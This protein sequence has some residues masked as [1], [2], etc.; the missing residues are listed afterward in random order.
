MEKV[1]LDLVTDCELGTTDKQKALYFLAQDYKRNFNTFCKDG[2]MYIQ[3]HQYKDND[4]VRIFES[5]SYIN[6]KTWWTDTGWLKIICGKDN[7]SARKMIEAIPDMAGTP[8]PE[9]VQAEIDKTFAMLLMKSHVKYNKTKDEYRIT[10]T[11]PKTKALLK[12]QYDLGKITIP[13]PDGISQ[14]IATHLKDKD[15]QSLNDALKTLK[16]RERKSV[17]NGNIEKLI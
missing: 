11:I 17:T 4:L 2:C 5:K 14:F 10:E 9:T 12:T 16:S 1:Y 3:E 13:E 7:I 15:G 8:G 6:T